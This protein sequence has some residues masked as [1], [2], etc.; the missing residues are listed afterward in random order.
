MK[1]SLFILVVCMLIVNFAALFQIEQVA[2]K[3]FLLTYLNV[4]TLFIVALYFLPR[5]FGKKNKS[6]YVPKKEFIL[7]NS[8]GQIIDLSDVSVKH[9]KHN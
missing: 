7:H 4:G 3:S 2:G 8:G 5:V 6:T 1:S 9:I